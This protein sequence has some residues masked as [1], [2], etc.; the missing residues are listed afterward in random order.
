MTWG[1]GLQIAEAQSQ[2]RRAAN[3]KAERSPGKGGVTQVSAEAGDPL[4]APLA[5]Q[6]DPSRPLE[7]VAASPEDSGA[8][9]PRLRRPLGPGP[10]GRPARR[11]PG[12]SKP[13]LGLTRPGYLFRETWKGGEDP[14]TEWPS[15]CLSG[16][17]LEATAHLTGDAG[18][19]PSR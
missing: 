1:K 2:L 17:K 18:S 9:T 6:V 16:G 13:P 11:G 19:S 14:K 3:P 15:S 12:L 8:A 10:L 7:L 5:S 4:L